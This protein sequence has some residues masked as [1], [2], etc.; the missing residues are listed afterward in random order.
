MIALLGFVALLIPL[1][2]TIGCQRAGTSPAGDVSADEQR[3]EDKNRASLQ[4][5]GKPATNRLAGETSLYLLMHAH[6]PVDWYPWGEEAL[7]KAQAEHKLIFL[8]IGYS[9]CYWCHV[10]ERESFMDDEVATLLNEHFVCIKV[11]R[12]ERPD[13][14]TI[15]MTALQI[16]FQLVHSP[17][18]GGWPLTMVLTP[19]ARPVIG[20]TYFPPRDKDGRTGLLSVLNRVQEAWREEPKQLRE[21]ADLLGKLVRRQLQEG[22]AAPEAGPDP[23]L[24]DDVLTAL[25]EEFDPEYGGFGYSPVNPRMPKFPQPSNLVFLLDRARREKGGTVGL[26]NR[27]FHTAGQASSGTHGQAESMLITTLERMAA[28][29]IRDHLG[30]GFHRYST[31]RFWAIPHFEKMLYDNAQLASVYAEAYRVTGRED[32][33]RVAEEIL[34][35]V[36]REMTSPEGGFY[37]AIDAET[38]AQEGRYYVWHRDELADLLDQQQFA[39]LADVYGI[40]KAG[41][42]ADRHVLLLPRPLQETAKNRQL[43]EAR[44][45]QQLGPV[46]EKLL[47]ARER[48]ER[49][50]TDTKLLTA[51]NGLMIRGFAD[52]GRVLD[53]DRYVETAENAASLM[54]EKLRNPEGRLLRSFAGGRARLNAYLDDYAFL[55]DGLIALHR[56]TA[57]PQWLQ[58]ADRLTTTQINLFWDDQRG[59]FFFTSSDHEIL[60]ARTKDPHDSALPSGNAVAVDNLVYLAREL[61]KPEYLD[62]AE[63]TLRAFAPLLEQM[64]SGMPRMAASLAAF[65]DAAQ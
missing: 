33:R 24:P 16:Y 49:P 42:L 13:I 48:R 40:G 32:F 29:G 20:G 50:A 63:T 3:A 10:M 51:W 30:G 43:T 37:A 15:Y 41:N 53:D 36:L 31:D 4:T 28:G 11:D 14:D 55:V 21:N 27:V 56:A 25:V 39:L 6:N 59:G 52:A 46:R 18:G 45:R 23:S 17:Q 9:S 2:V 54:L 47:Q 35:F 19:D 1:A 61:D 12:E 57:K 58:E 60:I 65:L 62:R 22:P 8:S 64:P 44:L 38:D 26:P 34:E 7:A 5:W